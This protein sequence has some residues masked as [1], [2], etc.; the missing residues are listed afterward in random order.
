MTDEP[1][2]LHSREPAASPSHVRRDPPPWRRRMSVTLW[3]AFLFLLLMAASLV[4][5]AQVTRDGLSRIDKL[6][7]MRMDAES[8]L[9]ELKDIETGERGFLVT[10]NP[11]FLEPYNDALTQI[12]ATLDRFIGED[13]NDGFDSSLSALRHLVQ[14]KLDLSAAAIK[15]ARLDNFDAGRSEV[16][17]GE[18]K[19][20]MDSIR[21]LVATIDANVDQRR[22]AIERRTRNRALW[23]SVTALAAAT[24]A[25]LLVAMAAVLIGRQS[26]A[27]LRLA[28]EG[29][30]LALNAAA[31]GTWEWDYQTDAVTASPV[32]RHLF[33]LP[34]DIPLTMSDLLAAVVPEDREE[35]EQALRGALRHDGCEWEGRIGAASE[36]AR[37]VKLSA[38]LYRDDTGQPTALR[39]VAQ[40]VSEI[41]DN[42]RRLRELETELWHAS[43]VATVGETASITAH[44]LG[45]PLSA[46]SSYVQGCQSMVRSGHYDN[47][48]LLKGL[49]R[50]NEALGRASAIVRNL[51]RYLRK[52][53]LHREPFDVNAAVKDAVQLGAIGFE[54]RGKGR[55]VWKLG[56]DLPATFADRTQIQQVIVNLARNAIEAMSNSALRELRVTTTPHEG[57]VR[58]AIADTGPGLPPDIAASPFRPFTTTKPNGLGL[59]LSICRSI[60]EAHGGTIAVES[61]PQGTTFTIDLPAASEERRVAA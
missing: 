36:S 55:I 33:S 2:P 22:F 21:R 30:A 46:A 47:E 38:G 42:E 18:G 58:L 15:A 26:A 19:F 9:T 28:E 44:E 32:A 60:V 31:L 12:T 27:Q 34:P 48:N 11:K 43:R 23:A 3:L 14:R 51:H 24:S 20:V 35:I 40:D 41:R 25:T 37:I 6:I 39:G 13:A 54:T 5:V 7:H 8:L 45:Q 59:G 50:G 57:C 10:A 29:R 52:Q 17:Q 56:A 53:A 1:S 16:A 4:V 61:G 49:E